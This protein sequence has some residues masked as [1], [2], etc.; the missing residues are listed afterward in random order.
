M[1]TRLSAKERRE[2]TS[3]DCDGQRKAYLR[4]FTPARRTTAPSCMDGPYTAISI[5]V[6]QSQFDRED[7]LE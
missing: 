4:S 3:S 2:A 7:V 5:V 1:M 6:F